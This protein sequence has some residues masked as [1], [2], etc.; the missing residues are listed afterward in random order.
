M[1]YKPVSGVAEASSSAGTVYATF[2]AVPHGLLPR[3]NPRGAIVV[4]SASSRMNI[5]TDSLPQPHVF[6]TTLTAA[7]YSDTFRFEPGWSS[8]LSNATDTAT[9]GYSTSLRNEICGVRES[10]RR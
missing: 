9:S 10:T 4:P 3:E 8:P 7:M 2:V 6:P 5:L 1:S